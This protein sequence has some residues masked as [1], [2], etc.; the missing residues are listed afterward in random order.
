LFII[1]PRCQTL[2]LWI[3]QKGTLK[4]FR[5][6]TCGYTEPIVNLKPL[7]TCEIK[8]M[9]QKLQEMKCEAK[10][11][12]KTQT[13]RNNWKSYICLLLNHKWEYFN[14]LKM[15]EGGRDWRLDNNPT[16]R[17]CKRC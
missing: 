5:C 16:T 1:C 10:E 8:E 2:L 14:R 6:A 7:T 11:K 4:D 17:I 9:T 3:D 13:K 15:T 12:L